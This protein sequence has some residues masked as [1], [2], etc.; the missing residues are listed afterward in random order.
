METKKQE[1][2]EHAGG[3]TQLL[4]KEEKKKYREVDV[5]DDGGVIKRVYVEG[6]GE[7][8][9]K[10]ME[11]IV[12][13]V[14][15]LED[16]TVF[17]KNLD[18][19]EAFKFII[20][21]GHVIKGWDIGI[22]SMRRG[23]KADLFIK[24]RYAYGPMGKPPHIQPD[25]NLVFTIEL[26]SA[27]NR[28]ITK[29][30]MDDFSRVQAILRLKEDGN[31]RFKEKKYKEAEGQYRDAISHLDTMNNENKETKD[32]RKTLWLNIAVATNSNKDYLECVKN[33]SKVLSVDPT[34]AKAV[35]LRGVAY[36]GLTNYEEACNNL[37]EAIKLNPSDK[38]IREE[39]ES[40]KKLR[41]QNK[42]K[43]GNLFA[44]F[45]KSGVY[46]DRDVK[47]TKHEDALPQYNPKNPK[48]FMDIQIGDDKPKRVMFELFKE[49]VP[50]TAENFRALCTGEKSSPS[51][52][53][54]YKGNVFHRIIKGFM[55]QGGDFENENGTGGSS[56]YGRNFED[57][58]TWLPHQIPGLLSMANSGKDT[59]GSQFF[60]T[61]KKTPHL[62]GKHT[63]FGRV[64]QGMTFIKEIEQL[65]TG[66]NDKP[67]NTVRIVN[68]GEIVE[69]V[70]ELD[71]LTS[72]LNE[73]E[74]ESKEESNI[75]E[76]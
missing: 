20:G 10:E 12:N 35:Y 25:Q 73:G 76:I 24:S 6:Y 32:L 36:K 17:D 75:V 39:F 71:D 27:N 69:E 13:Y 11:V 33:A 38:K 34:N 31:I 14:G 60:V 7:C 58:R 63:V 8:P 67:F 64:I 72:N 70:N 54:H 55:M 46:S 18:R 28:R 68:C 57:E 29:W 40:S 23:E 74:E 9:E 4:N 15:M 5:N 45:L 2:Q 26:L 19:D 50:I 59:N 41:D 52:K 66:A 16:G 30:Q 42:N 53:L 62:N 43:E 21:V 3:Q 56:I 49:K 44:Q 47:L 22:L 1:G 37:K 51:K 48:V 65:E 61:F